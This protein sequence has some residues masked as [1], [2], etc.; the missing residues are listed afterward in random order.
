LHSIQEVY[1]LSKEQAKLGYPIDLEA[2][3]TYCNVGL[4]MLFIQ[5][6]AEYTFI[7]TQ[8]NK[9]NYRTGTRVRVTGVTQA[10]GY[11]IAIGNAKIQSLGCLLY[12]SRCV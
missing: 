1:A 10:P 2:V 5:D 3:V 12:T 9:T 4:Q 7:G 11:A 6:N 8:D